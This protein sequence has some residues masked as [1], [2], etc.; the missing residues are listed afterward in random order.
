MSDHKIPVAGLPGRSLGFLTP[1][2]INVGPA[3]ALLLIAGLSVW[4]LA[5]TGAPAN[6]GP[7]DEA[8]PAS[9]SSIQGVQTVMSQANPFSLDISVRGESRALRKAAL[10]ARRNAFV[11]AVHVEKGQDVSAGDILVTLRIPDFDAR[12][13]EVALRLSEAQR[14]LA[15]IESLHARGLSTEDSLRDARTQLGAAESSWAGIESERSD[16]EIRAPFAGRINSLDAEEEDLVSPGATLGEILDLSSVVIEASIPQKHI[17]MLTLGTPVVADL[18]TGQ[19]AP[20]EIT[21][22]SA[23]AQTSTRTFPVEATI[24]NPNQTILAGVSTTLTIEGPRVPAHA[25]PSA[26]LSLDEDGRLI[27]KTIENDRVKA[28][29][30]TIVSSDLTSVRVSGL[31]ERAHI[32]TVGQGF[33]RHGDPARPE[34]AE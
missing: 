14:H 30:V 22:I 17:S 16:L 9:H 24:P 8:D 10:N 25:L 33:L 11:A 21:F 12:A 2:R 15:N 28:V 26:Y 4:M 23:Q 13:A 19:S 20:G 29:P 7:A 32:I 1:A 3:L 34:A 18:V 5:P 27:V 6:H 31:P